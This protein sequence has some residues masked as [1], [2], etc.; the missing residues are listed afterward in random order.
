VSASVGT[1]VA[2]AAAF[3]A[4]N[5]DDVVVLTALFGLA[6]KGGRLRERHVVVGQVIGLAALVA[7]AGAGAAGLTLVSDDVVGLLG[8]VPLGLG[9][10]GL[11][12]VV[13]GVPHGGPVAPVVGGT[14][15]VAALTIAGGADNVAVYVPFLADQD[16]GEIALVVVVFAV[17]LAAW[18]AGTRWLA[19]RP[20][21]AR[22]IARRGHVLVPLLLIALGLGILAGTGGLGSALDV[23]TG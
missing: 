10:L 15:G 2:A 4:T 9:L 6:R 17:L 8:L 23:V 11:A 7:A 12:A 5:L 20:A 18:L 22:V 3:G 16:A 1:A 19:G 13:R 21:V 14:L